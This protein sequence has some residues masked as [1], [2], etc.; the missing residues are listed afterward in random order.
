MKSTVI[1]KR[2]LS[3]EETESLERE[4]ENIF[5]NCT[6]DRRL[7]SRICKELQKFNTKETK[8]LINKWTNKM[9]RQFST[10]STSD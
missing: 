5:T 10:R 8:L 1:E 6:S 2:Q 4:W 7:I 9:N 3:V